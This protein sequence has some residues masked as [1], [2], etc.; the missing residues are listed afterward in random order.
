[1]RKILLYYL[2]FIVESLSAQ[3]VVQK[4]D[5]AWSTFSKDEQLRHAIVGF[6]VVDSKTGKLIFERNAQVGLAPA[7]TQKII[8]SVAAFELLGKE[9]RYK[10]ELGYDGKIKEG[11]L[12]GN[13][14]LLGSG[15]P[16]LGSWRWITTKDSVLL[17]KWL[18]AV[19][20]AKIKKITGSVSF[21]WSRYSYQSIPDG[22]PWQDIGNY[23]GAGAY[24]LNWKENQFD[25]KLKSGNQL[26][27]PVQILSTDDNYVHE[28]KTAGAGSGDNAYGYLPI[29]HGLA[30]IKGTIPVNENSFAISLADPDPIENILKSLGW[31][32]ELNSIHSEPAEGHHSNRN[33]SP[34][35]VK[36]IIIN[37][38]W[39]PSLDSINFYFLRKS[40]NLY[41]EALVKTISYNNTGIGDTEKGVDILRD[42][43]VDNGF[44]KTALNII[45]GSGLSPQNRVTTDALVKVLQ[46]AK[47]RSWFSSFYN[48]LP[49]F[50]GMKMKS[51]SIGGVRAYAGYHKATSGKEYSFCIIVNNFDGSSA[52]IVKKMYKL[53]DILK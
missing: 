38:H 24:V 52:E 21:D 36:P 15:D 40:V 13:L 5:Q 46:Y 20:S 11:I 22:W 23:Y 53:L 35:N 14:Y 10:T 44:D 47:T 16:T 42:F 26:N 45:D 30:L 7:S 28:L 9:Y 41:G 19:R 33:G 32:L 39:S 25:I 27:V 29:G 51:G 2:L 18:E 43:F 17:S 37:T 50:N 8:T 49:E 48:A 34:F 31:W 4:L 1:M 3:T 6:S 12:E